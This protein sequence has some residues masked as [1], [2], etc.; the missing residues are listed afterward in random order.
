MTN[1]SALDPIRQFDDVQFLTIAEV[2]LVLRLSK[3]TV[4]R[5]AHSGELDSRRVGRSFRIPVQAVRKFLEPLA[6]QPE[7]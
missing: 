3:M 5:M 4:Y 6:D 2:A 7:S 1:S